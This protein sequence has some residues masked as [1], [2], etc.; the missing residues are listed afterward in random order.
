[1]GFALFAVMP[2]L[3]LVLD[4]QTRRFWVFRFRY[5][6]MQMVKYIE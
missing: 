3:D 4:P 5:S 1:M 2:V 6:E